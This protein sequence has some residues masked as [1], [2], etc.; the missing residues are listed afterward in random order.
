MAID[1]GRSIQRD[2]AVEN[3]NE[4]ERSKEELGAGIFN[5]EGKRKY[6]SQRS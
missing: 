2:F 1:L 3:P 6:Q 5:E 4:S